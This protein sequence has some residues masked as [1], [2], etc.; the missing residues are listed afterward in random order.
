MK[1]ISLVLSALLLVMFVFTSCEKDNEFDEDALPAKF[2]VDIPDAVSHSSNKKSAKV[3]QLGGDEV[4]EHMR[5]FIA[6][7]EGAADIVQSLIYAIR[8]Y[9]LNQAQNFSYVSDEDGRTKNVNVT[10]NST[11]NG[12]TWKYQLTLTD[13]LEEG[14]DHDGIGLQIFWNNNP[15]K[16]VALLYPYNVNRKDSPDYWEKGMFQIEYSEAQEYGYEKSMIVSI[17]EIPVPGYDEYEMRSMKMFVGKN[18]DIVDVYGNSA[19]PNATLFNSGTGFDWAFVASSNEIE[20]LAVAE[21]GLPPYDLDESSREV[22]L[23]DYSIYNVLAS[24]IEDWYYEQH[25]TQIDSLTLASYL[26]NAE[27]PGYFNQ[28]GFIQSGQAPIE[29]Y[30][31][32]EQNIESLSP[33]NPLSIAELKLEFKNENESA[34]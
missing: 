27:A 15:I 3:D 30:K 7:G 1:K 6:V 21:V 17:A 5:M 28:D 20:Q 18:G 25:G 9:D 29:D 34:K 16:G 13:A 31:P 14:G 10:E 24:L 33:Y 26:E 32:L 23:E 22:I 12:Q 19:H 11:F 8:K 2:K 4:Y